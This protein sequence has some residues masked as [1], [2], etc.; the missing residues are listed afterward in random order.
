[1]V[2][3][4]IQICQ[5]QKKKN[6]K[7]KHSVQGYVWL[8]YQSS[9]EIECKSHME[10]KIFIATLIKRKM[11]LILINFNPLYPEYYYFNR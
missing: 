4:T 3:G 7:T 9:T 2:L 1:M 11:K 8:E 6:Q 5:R 10:F